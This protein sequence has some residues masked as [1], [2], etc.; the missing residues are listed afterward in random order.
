MTWFPCR[1]GF[2]STP[3]TPTRVSEPDSSVVPNVSIKRHQCYYRPFS[4]TQPGFCHRY[5]RWVEHGLLFWL[6][7]APS[8]P[9]LWIT[10]EKKSPEWRY[11]A[12]ESTPA[13]C[14]SLIWEG[15]TDRGPSGAPRCF[16]SWCSTVPRTG[17][18]GI[19]RS[20]EKKKKKSN[21]VEALMWNSLF[22][23][24]PNPEKNTSSIPL[25]TLG[26]IWMKHQ[27]LKFALILWDTGLFRCFHQK[28]G[29]SVKLKSRI[30]IQN[31]KKV[32][33]YKI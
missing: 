11:A 25:K 21:K 7:E 33:F 1:A 15:S 23:K 22:I 32:R 28:Y 10:Q 29:C 9:Q 27:W 12:D 8:G 13:E 19:E 16:Q 26:F 5:Y 17:P 2:S 3:E 31:N 4:K 30:L 14:G 6:Y 18:P 24:L 20:S